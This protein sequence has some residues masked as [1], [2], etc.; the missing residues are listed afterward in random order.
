MKFEKGDGEMREL[1][2]KLHRE[3]VL[4]KAEFVELLKGFNKDD[5]QYLFSQSELADELFGKIYIQVD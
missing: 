4:S 5:A 3:K 1:I 2:D